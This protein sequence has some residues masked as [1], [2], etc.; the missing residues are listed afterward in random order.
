MSVMC[1]L[2]VSMLINVLLYVFVC[3]LC[4]AFI[5]KHLRLDECNKIHSYLLIGYF[6]D[7]SIQLHSYLLCPGLW[8]PVYNQHC[9]ACF[10]S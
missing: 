7:D 1:L 4:M 3:L 9:N 10:L 5:C 2:F 8:L 6:W